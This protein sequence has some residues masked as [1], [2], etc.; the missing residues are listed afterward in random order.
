MHCRTLS[1][2]QRKTPM[3][4]SSSIRRKK[5]FLSGR[6]EHRSPP[7]GES[8]R[9]K[10]R[11]RKSRGEITPAPAPFDSR[12]KD[13]TSYASRRESLA[14]RTR[15]SSR[16]PPSLPRRSGSKHLKKRR[17]TFK[18]LVFP[19]LGSGPVRGAPGRGSGPDLGVPP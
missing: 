7:V 17:V 4:Y 3:Y 13:F 19:W 14:Q 8:D 2:S 1:A 6:L 11:K 9:G 15:D 10:Y 12:T 5:R 18:G 16:S